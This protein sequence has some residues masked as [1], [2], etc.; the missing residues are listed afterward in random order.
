MCCVFTKTHARH[1]NCCSRAS[2]GKS[3]PINWFV[4]VRCQKAECSRSPDSVYT[5]QL[6][7]VLLLAGDIEINPGPVNFGFGNCR[8]IRNKGPAISDLMTSACIDIFGL[9]ETH[10]RVNDTPSFLEELTPDGYKLFHSPRLGKT[11]GGVGFL[12]KK[13][14]NCSTV[15]MPTFGSFEYIAISIQSRNR[16]LTF[17]SIYRPPGD[18][19]S[20]FLDEFM[21]FFGFISSLSSPTVICGDFNIHLDTDTTSSSNFQ[22]NA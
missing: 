12:I 7:I 14:F 4:F 9:T 19:I 3:Q 22:I 10:I 11:G 16:T 15:A 1:L 8:S 5:F 20:L 6:S 2:S 18:G 21:S 17:A 13:D